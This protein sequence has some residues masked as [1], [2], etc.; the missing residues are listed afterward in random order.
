MEL[1]PL[2]K[3]QKSIWNMEQYF[4]G[5]IANITG[6]AIFTEAVNIPALQ[7][8]LNRTVEQ[9]D[10]LRIR[11]KTQNGIPM[12]YIGAY[13]SF[14][15]ETIAFGTEKEFAEWISILAKTPFDLNSDLYKI[16]IIS[17]NGNLGFVLHLHHLTAD[18]WTLNLFA[19]NVMNNLKG[20]PVNTNSYI[21][22][23]AIED[24]Y[25][26]SARSEKDRNYFL[27]DFE[28]CAEPIFL[29]DKQVKSTASERLSF[30]I[31]TTDTAE[32]QKYCFD[33]GISPYTLFMNALATYV[34][35]VKSAQDFY[36]G[37]SVLNRV[38]RK[39]KDTAGIYINTVPIRFH[40]DESQSSFENLQYSANTLMG[41]FRHQKYQYSDLLRDIRE[42]YSFA[43]KLYDIML[44][45]QNAVMPDGIRTEWLFCGCQ[46]E[47][48]NIHINDRQRKGVFH[49]D[50]DYQTELFNE[51]D[52]ERLHGHLTNIIFDMI[53]N[54]DKKPHELSLLSESE[55]WQVVFDFN[56]TAIDY[57]KEKCIH[58]LFEE[59]AAKTPDRAAVIFEDV[60]YTYSQINDMANSLAHLLREKG[61]ERNDIVPI[62][63]KRSHKIIVAQLAILKAGGAYMPVDP[64]YPKDR[65]AFLLE[66]A[67][68][69]TALILKV[70]VDGINME[71]DTV[72]SGNIAAI[73]NINSSNDLFCAL[74]TS[75]STGAPKGTLL[76]HKNIIN[77]AYGSKNVYDNVQT[78]LSTTAVVFDVYMQESLLSLCWGIKVVYLSDQELSNQTLFETT[79]EKHTD[80]YIFQT[81]TKLESYIA[82]SKTKKFLKHINSFVVGGEAFPKRLFDLI[83][84]HNICAK[85]NQPS[86]KMRITNIYGPAETTA[87]SSTAILVSNDITIGRPIA[88]TQIYILD[89]FNNPLPIGVAGELCI[90]GDGV[91]LGYLNRP[92]LTVEKFVANPFVKGNRMY[93]TGDLARWRED[94][95]LEFIGRMD[96]Q[97]KIR[98]LRIELGEIETTMAGFHGI[99]QVVVI[100]KKDENNRQYICAYYISNGDIDEKVM[101]TELA[102]KLPRYM[103]PH[104]FMRLEALPTTPSG[105]TDRNAV[106]T[107]DFFN[108][109]SDVE[110]IAPS[111]EEEKAVVALMQKVLN[112]Q[113]IGMDDNFFDLGGDSLKAIEFVSK[114]HYEGIRFSLQDVFDNPTAAL[115]L[116]HIAEGNRQSVQYHAE[117]FT[118]IHQLLQ[119]NTIVADAPLVKQSLG[120]VLITGATGW[121]GV[122]VLDEFLSVEQGIA[123]CLVR[124]ADLNDSRDRL[125]MV[126]ERYFGNKHIG[127]DRIVAICGDITEEIV[128]GKPID[129][130]IHCAAN[131]KHYGSYQHSHD[132]NVVGTQEI[133][134][135]A[136][137]KEAKLLHISTASVSGNGFDS[138]PDFPPTVFDETKLYIGQPLDNVYV[139][140]KFESEIAVLQA[141]LEGL[142]A[143]VMRVGNLANRQGD[144]RF[145]YNH[146]TNATLTRIKA[147]ADLGL[148]PR[149]MEDF[150]LEFS[151]VDDTAK[152][153]IKLAQYWDDRHSVFH[154]Y[155]S[156]PIR[157][158]EL[159]KALRAASMKMKA[160]PEAEF[161]QA[162]CEAGNTPEC[163]HIYEA[164]I[165]D[166]GADGALLFGSSITL[167]GD[168][169]EWQ[170]K[171][172]GFSWLPV[173]SEYLKGY[174][175]YFK[176]IRYWGD[177]EGDAK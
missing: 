86:K 82:N 136:K 33:N 109:Q 62:I 87:W 79:I 144:Y 164:F 155:H 114:A 118:A 125:N 31:G 161:V 36:I 85:T 97:V 32:I 54:P 112:L 44:N 81:P 48:L 10:S 64:N 154:A 34:Y 3:P 39:E 160:V 60:E 165:H 173:Y 35:R 37:T 128:F 168:F 91:G 102:K 61:V 43:D 177:V 55:Y 65:I 2:T 68:C 45:Y 153:I 6:S 24:E 71:D 40:I 130:I 73:D 66:D 134:A 46:S 156:T 163:K 15:L 105:K 129:A 141:K 127:C 169:T 152:A 1:Y 110:Y 72:F 159:V 41:A 76:T 23:L 5:S 115:L 162:V 123:Y 108:I 166:I 167:N 95:R 132:I 139:R 107:P 52:I 158:A 75:G 131:V 94:G 106:P 93:K 150:L 53:A 148:F 18:A 133:I 116:R 29:S 157:F 145:Q 51:R 58:Q 175:D 103:I 26:K 50:Y 174:I 138:S 28:K 8:A 140:S 11:I 100:D 126:L 151:P 89:K 17:V 170:L 47:S 25:E 80:C 171:R 12:Q 88:N 121:L 172:A 42:K 59:Q 104:F 119:G 14:E 16:F 149:Q 22:Y 19:A 38:G 21:D 98:G 111:T 84:F 4:G 30:T 113:K 176:N 20:E 146:S 99:Q 143:A 135:L 117:D 92:E 63:A 13:E 70:A 77:F 90:S 74:H 56:D 122:H 101:R 78:T 142:A 96:N 67:K 137:E 57:P 124:G 147:F 49:L 7:A 83:C 9:S 27:A 120:D 69:K